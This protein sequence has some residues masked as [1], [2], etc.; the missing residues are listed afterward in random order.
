MEFALDAFIVKAMP[1]LKTILWAVVGLVLFI[2]LAYYLF[3]VRQRRKWF[4]NIWEQKANGKLYLV[5]KDVLLEK[6][7]NQGKQT[8]Y[9]LKRN[10]RETLPPP[11]ECVDRDGRKEVTNYLRILD[12]YIP[13]E[14]EVSIPEEKKKFVK[15][16]K[17]SILAIPNLGRGEIDERY[18]HVPLNNAI[19]GKINFSPID[20][21]VNMMRINALDNR[22]KMYQDV[23]D[24]MQKYG[25]LVA[26]GMIIV[27]II[28]VLYLSYDYSQNV[29]NGA[30][31]N[32]ASALNAVA[33][34][35]GVAPRS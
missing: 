9:W 23:K 25:H 21:D 12:D 17:E 32:V 13:L 8:A 29:I 28:V 10:R 22:E 19:M 18:I 30:G 3:V 5:G 27:L 2:I 26:I 31:Q 33:D 15:R 6:R 14:R 35:M 20:Y 11:E 4:V 24:W 1:V 34:K 7:F 16:V